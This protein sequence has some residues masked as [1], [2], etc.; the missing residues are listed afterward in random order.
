MHDYESRHHVSNLIAWV[1]I[2]GLPQK[3]THLDRY[4]ITDRL[5]EILETFHTVTLGYP[6]QVC[7]IL[8]RSIAFI[9]Y[10]AELIL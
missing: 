7:R 5:H 2:M 6:H 1:N 9:R 10:I 3:S 4:F 8:H